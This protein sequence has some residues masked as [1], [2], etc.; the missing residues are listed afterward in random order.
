MSSSTTQDTHTSQGSPVYT[1]S[2]GTTTYG[3]PLE[4]T[5]TTTT[6]ATPENTVIGYPCHVQVPVND[7]NT[8]TT[9]AANELDHE[10]PQGN[11]VSSAESCCVICIF[12]AIFI[13]VGCIAA[14]SI[15]RGRYDD[16]SP[17][18]RVD[19]V[20]V[21]PFNVSNSQLNAKWLILFYLENPNRVSSL[22]Y[23]NLQVSVNYQNQ[24]ES[25]SGTVFPPFLQY[26]KNQTSLNGK[27]NVL[28][29]KLN[30]SAANAIA[31]DIGRGEIGFDV[32]L[33]GVM[34]LIVSSS[35]LKTFFVDVLCG[36]VK[37]VLPAN[38]SEGG[39]MVDGPT[40]CAVY[41]RPYHDHDYSIDSYGYTLE[42]TTTNTTTPTATT[43]TAATTTV[44]G[45]P[46]VLQAP[47]SY[48]PPRD[49]NAIFFVT[50]LV[51]ATSPIWPGRQLA[52]LRLTLK[53]LGSESTP[54][55]I[56]GISYD[57]IDA[58]VF[59]KN[60]SLGG[61]IFAPFRQASKNHTSYVGNVDTLSEKLNSTVATAIA[62]DMAEGEVDFDVKLQARMRFIA[63]PTPP[64]YLPIF[65]VAA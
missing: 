12:F 14:M 26:S 40:Q 6:T 61:A 20:S 63:W 28:S 46:R 56:R 17:K 7:V 44:A 33:H 24:T 31:L 65:F 47:P 11:Q 59:Y 50:F 9:T 55:R 39:S 30:G 19:S 34:R 3:Y 51:L 62:R 64:V 57:S 58:S 10:P 29:E 15:V 38:L 36:G 53:L 5:V 1:T 16:H 43:A 32:Q 22:A 41:K 4:Q 23:E 37:V 60:D 21:S 2:Y 13:F 45:Y 18:L 8:Y 42:E 54:S 25:F 48:T 49:Y 52:R 27:I 35:T